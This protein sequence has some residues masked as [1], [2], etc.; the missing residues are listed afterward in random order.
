MKG[1]QIQLVVDLWKKPYGKPIVVLIGFF[2]VFLAFD[3]IV[4]SGS[5]IFYDSHPFGSPIEF[6]A[7]TAGV[8]YRIAIFIG[9]KKSEYRFR[10]QLFDP[11]GNK[12]VDEED[13]F[14]RNKRSFVFTP[15]E[16]GTYTLKIQS[17]YGSGPPRVMVSVH[18]NNRS[19]ISHRF[20]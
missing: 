5:N 6:Y 8:K 3:Y 12:I 20:R 17:V 15:D 4:L 13:S 1:Q 19:I 16:V 2:L 11:D 7:D 10:Y 18:Q 14:G 9:N